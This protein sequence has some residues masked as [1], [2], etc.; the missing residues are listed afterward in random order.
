M[1]QI[2]IIIQQIILIGICIDAVNGFVVISKHWAATGMKGDLLPIRLRM[3]VDAPK[4]IPP[5]TFI[6]CARDA[7]KATKRALEDGLKLLEVEFPPLPLE[8]LEDSSSSA[9]DIADASTRWALEFSKTF[10]DAGKVTII[11]PDQPELDSAIQYVDMEGGANPMPNVTLATIR[12]DSIARAKSLDQIFQSVFGATVGGIVESI[13][14]TSLY[15]ALVSS[16]QELTDLEKLHKLD[17]DVPIVF[18]NLRLDILVI[19]IT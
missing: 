9:R 19:F 18:F 12:A 17:P 11:Y 14:D 16:T 13:P 2:I 6:D 10:S 4:A 3:L 8:Y 5:T 15:V 1:M 7:A